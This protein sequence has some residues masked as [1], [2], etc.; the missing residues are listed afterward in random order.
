VSIPHDKRPR[1]RTPHEDRMFQ[2]AL[3]VGYGLTN[4]STG[5]GIKGLGAIDSNINTATCMP[6]PRSSG[7]NR[8]G[9]IQGLRRGRRSRCRA[10]TGYRLSRHLPRS[11]GSGSAI[12]TRSDGSSMCTKRGLGDARLS[13]ISRC[14]TVVKG[15]TYSMKY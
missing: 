9:A 7:N 3:S 12:G 2:L 1:R 13:V 10:M 5:L 14:I 8:H 11:L 4:L 15:G 6:L